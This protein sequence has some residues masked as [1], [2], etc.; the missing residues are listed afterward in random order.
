MKPI[1]TRIFKTAFNQITVV[2]SMI[3]LLNSCA[4]KKGNDQIL[5]NSTPDTLIRVASFGSIKNLDRL[6]KVDRDGLLFDQ[7]MANDFHLP[8][9]K[10]DSAAIINYFVETSYS[11]LGRREFKQWDLVVV[12][13]VVFQI[14][15]QNKPNPERPLFPNRP[16]IELVGMI[17]LLLGFSFF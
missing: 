11:Q 9:K 1:S 10:R 16:K 8:K 5:K 4:V 12:R 15:V 17:L 13:G 14:N 6:K 3:F 2:L 7:Y